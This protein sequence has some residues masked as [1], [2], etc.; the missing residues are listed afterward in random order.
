[1]DKAVKNA[2]I[3]RYSSEG[4]IVELEDLMVVEQGIEI[5]QR[6]AIQKGLL[7]THLR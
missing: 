7:F 5:W 3:K 1:M 2:L 4:G 6:G